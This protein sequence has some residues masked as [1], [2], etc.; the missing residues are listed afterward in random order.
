MLSTAISVAPASLFLA[1]VA[2]NSLRDVGNFG[3][4]RKIE[5]LGIGGVGNLGRFGEVA[6]VQAK[7]SALQVTEI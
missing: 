7:A 2:V 5:G 1:V 3:I 6:V 4:L